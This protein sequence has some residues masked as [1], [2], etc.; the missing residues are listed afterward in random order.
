MGKDFWNDVNNAYE[1]NRSALIVGLDP[2][3]DSMPSTISNS[4]VDIEIFLTDIIDSTSDLV[5]GYKPNLAFYLALGKNGIILLHNVIEHIKTDY[6]ELVVIIDGKFNDVSHTAEK[7]SEFAK[8]LGADAVTLNPYLGKDTLAPFMNKGLAII[9]LCVT[10]NPSFADLECLMVD[11][12]PM[13]L[14]VAEYANRWSEQFGSRIG[15][16]VGATHP[17]VFGKIREKAPYSPFLIPGIGVQ[18]G[19]IEKSVRYGIT[20]DSFPPMIVSARSILYASSDEDYAQAARDKAQKTKLKIN[21][22]IK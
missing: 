16:V 18:G 22:L 3:I 14:S 9:M 5:C 12:E 10:S 13:Y 4:V 1:K 6:P 8:S 11:N 19:D 2:I 17:E 21:S 15:L 7:Y 20:Q